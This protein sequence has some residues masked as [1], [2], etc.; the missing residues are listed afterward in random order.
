MSHHKHWIVESICPRCEKT[1]IV[2]V[3]EREMV[4]RVHCQHCA[5]L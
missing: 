3:P 4:V 2:E 1:N 5:W